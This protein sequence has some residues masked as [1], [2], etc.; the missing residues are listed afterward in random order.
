MPTEKTLLL[1]NIGQ[2]LTLR[3]AKGPRRGAELRELGIVEDG[4]VLCAGGKIVSAGTTKDAL[5]DPWIK[6]N[7]KKIEEIDCAGKV[8]VPGFVD[9]H[10]HLIFAGPRLVD[11]EKRVAGATYEEIAEAGGGIRSSV[12]GVRKAPVKELAAKALAALEEMGA[13]G[14]TTVEA[15]SGYGLS[16]EAEIKSLEAI[17]EAAAQWPGTV[18]PTLLGAHVVPPEFKGK[19]EK[20]VREV[21][22]K[23]IPQAAKKKLAAFVDIFCDRGAFTVEDA[24]RIFEAAQKHG[25]EVRA[26]MCQLTASE[27]WRLLRFKPASLDH[28]DCVGDEDIPQLARRDTVVTL[29]PGANYFLGLK[30]YPDARRM[31]EAGVPVAL[32]TDY[33]PG[34]SPTTS[35]AFV[36]SLACTQMKMTPAEAIAAGTINGAH[37]LRLGERKGSIETGKDADL[38]VFDV[39]DYREIPYWVAGNRCQATV[40]NGQLTIPSGG[41]LQ[42]GALVRPGRTFRF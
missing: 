26:H 34:T 27:V 9:S 16:T 20:Y 17:R 15:K 38:A 5:R 31:I 2:L 6:K 37:A 22:E 40:L 18:V 32:A 3:G 13:Q 24:E 25:L 1:T 19:P 35:M 36:M 21:A 10:T 8:V 11:F 23:M 4:A 33:N 7:R 14:T 30:Q 42:A 39:G 28:M 41:R 29:L 12:A